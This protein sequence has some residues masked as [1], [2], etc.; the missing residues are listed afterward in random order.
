M[1]EVIEKNHAK[2][3]ERYKRQILERQKKEERLTAFIA[4][5][6]V[7]LTLGVI[8]LCDMQTKNDLQNCINKGY[9]KNYCIEKL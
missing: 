2:A 9:S 3:Y 1:K 6:I 7:A 8:L 4:T 5:F